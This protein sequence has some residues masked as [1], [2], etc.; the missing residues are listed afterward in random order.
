MSYPRYGL[1]QAVVT[2]NS[3]FYKRGHIRVRVSTFYSGDINWD[4]SNPYDDREFKQSL[5]DD[6]KCLVYMPIGGGNGHGFF[7]L[8]QVNSIGVVSFIDGNLKNA[9][10]MGSFVNP[11]YDKDGNF[12]NANM[13]NDTLEKEGAGTEGVTV[14]G[15]NVD[16]KGGGVVFRQKSTVSG[17]DD[18]K[19]MNWDN[20]RTENLMV[21]DKNNL[22]LLHVTKWEEKNNS[23]VPVKYHEVS[24]V[25]DTDTASD[26]FNEVIVNVKTFI[27]TDDNN[28]DEYGIEIKDKQVNII[29]KDSKNKIENNIKANQ[30]EILLTSKNTNSQKMS[31]VSVTP[32]ET[33]I[34]NKESSVTVNEKEVNI[35]GDRRVTIS[36]KEVLLGGLAEEYVVT[37]NIA[38]S[39]RMEDGTIL[40]SSNVAK[41]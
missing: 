2:D 24:I 40:S 3:E 15:K 10:W 5:G 22:K 38:F 35:S 23:L 31:S 27:I 14:E 1:Y 33:V 16:I 30:E 17:E 11:K 12:K 4:L 18:G 25:K 37:S 21:F 26:N 34:F 28:I 7:S 41:A 9:I 20:N 29:T 8:P 32:A 39:F 13:P 6:I 19:G 36:G